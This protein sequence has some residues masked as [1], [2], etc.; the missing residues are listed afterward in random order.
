MTRW[1][2]RFRG[3]ALAA[4]RARRAV[5]ERLRGELCEPLLSDVELL[6]SELATNSLRHGEADESGDLAVEVDVEDDRVR[7]R[8]CDAGRGFDRRT[9]APHPDGSGGY[10][11]LLLDR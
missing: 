8:M 5:R 4:R 9:P 10:G 6:V 7:L 3:D 1:R 2:Q 11:L